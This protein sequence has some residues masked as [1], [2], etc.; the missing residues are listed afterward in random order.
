MAKTLKEA[1]LEKFADLQ[2]LG[3]APTT[4]PPME[5]EGPAVVVDMSSGNYSDAGGRRQR[6]SRGG[7]GGGYDEDTRRG[8]DEP[9]RPRSRPRR[10]ERGGQRGRPG[11][12]GGGRAPTA[13][14]GGPPPRF[15]GP[16]REGAPARP[17]RRWARAPV[18][19]GATGRR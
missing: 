12:G 3:I 2:Q 16:P 7:A 6:F 19:G 11:G 18:A 14:R 5:D 15:G 13:G 9:I 10:P 8:G 4:A 1:L 17:P